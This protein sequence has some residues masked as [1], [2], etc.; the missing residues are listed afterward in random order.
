MP[1]DCVS[2]R[3]HEEM[4]ENTLGDLKR[5]K[6]GRKQKHEL[7][8][9]SEHNCDRNPVIFYSHDLSVKDK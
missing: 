4:A 1:D 5:G 2:V 3:G 9:M 6:T 8:G 7:R